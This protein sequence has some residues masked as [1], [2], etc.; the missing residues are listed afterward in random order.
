MVIP[1]RWV[2]DFL[3]KAYWPL[4]QTSKLDQPKRLYI[5]RSKALSRK[6]SNEPELQQVLS[7]F[8][9]TSVCL[10]DLP[11][12]QQIELFT[13][14][15]VVCS[16][17]GAGLTNTFFCKPGTKLIEIVQP[18]FPVICYWSWAAVCDLAYY[19]VLGDGPIVDYMDWSLY[20]AQSS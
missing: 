18:Q 19:F 13:N 11:L 10:E 5:S 7:S 3:R 4:L 14:A 20:E 8:G 16:L 9:F 1:P 17:H 6:I 15:E 2:A 12:I